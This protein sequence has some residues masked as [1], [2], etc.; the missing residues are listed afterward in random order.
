MLA[1]QHFSH[2]RT[3]Q[4]THG[5]IKHHFHYWGFGIFHG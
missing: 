3:A 1:P 4:A 5:T 2:Q